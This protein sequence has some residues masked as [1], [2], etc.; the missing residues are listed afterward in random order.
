MYL[1]TMYRDGAK[2]ARWTVHHLPGKFD[3]S[4]KIHGLRDKLLVNAAQFLK[5]KR[6]VGSASEGYA[7]P[8][9]AYD[10]AFKLMNIPERFDFFVLDMI[11]AKPKFYYPTRVELINPAANPAGDAAL[12]AGVVILK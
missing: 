6:I 11:G 10:N 9:G 4:K 8:K 7:K 12:D 1:L 3:T 2:Q 5:K